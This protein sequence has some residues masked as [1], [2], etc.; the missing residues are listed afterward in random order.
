M[1]KFSDDEL[2][3]LYRQG[4]T[5]REIAQRLSVTQAAIHYR[6]EKLGLTNNCNKDDEVDPLQVE[7]LHHMG[8]TNVGIALLLQ[9]SAAAVTLHANG[10]GLKDNYHI[11]KE[12]ID[13]P[14]TAKN[15]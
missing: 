15:R 5:N 7:I 11:I 13:Q 4:L 2:L 8:L 9:T 12:I 6:L 10:C 3:E 1:N 14:V